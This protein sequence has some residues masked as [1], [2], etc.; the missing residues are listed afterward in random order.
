MINNIYDDE[1][2]Y[3][4]ISLESSELIKSSGSLVYNTY[5]T[6]EAEYPIQYKGFELV[7]N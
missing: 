3:Q 2:M 7:L 1:T 5:R 6:T 4:V